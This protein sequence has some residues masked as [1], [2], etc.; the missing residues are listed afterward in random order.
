MSQEPPNPAET[1]FPP[2]PIPIFYMHPG[3]HPFCHRPGCFCM[4]HHTELEAFLLSVIG[5]E[6]KLRMVVN[7]T[8][9]W[10]GHNGRS[11][12]S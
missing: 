1:A 3:E 5:K 8:I 12:A 4:E 9:A 6:L 2:T 7:G 11:T 10:E